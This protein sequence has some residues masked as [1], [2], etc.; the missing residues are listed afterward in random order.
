MSNQVITTKN[1]TTQTTLFPEVK[2][3]RKASKRSLAPTFKPYNNRQ[4]QVI[5]D[6]EEL[7]PENHEARVVDEMVETISDERLFSY[8][9][10]GGRAAFHPKM[11]LKIILYGYTQKVYSCRG[12]AKLTKYPCDVAGCDATA[13][14][15]YH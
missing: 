15:P 11:M 12:I 2:Q 6:I 10:G 9:K 8:Y 14:L 5:F 1:N 13:R 4:V 7:I 3:E